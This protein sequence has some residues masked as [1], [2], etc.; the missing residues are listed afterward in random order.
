MKPTDVLLKQLTQLF[1]PD[2]SLPQF[3]QHTCHKQLG[4]TDCGIFSLAYAINVLR[5]NNPQHIRYDQSKMR[6]HL[7]CCFESGKFSLFPKYC[8]VDVITPTKTEVEKQQQDA[9]WVT[10]KRYN[11]RTRCMKN[12]VPT[13]V[14]NENRYASLSELDDKIFQ[15]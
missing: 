5:G 15:T 10:P 3:K 7:I 14:I 6:E 8:T 11:F 13:G 1:S 12:K 9:S 4:A 2:D